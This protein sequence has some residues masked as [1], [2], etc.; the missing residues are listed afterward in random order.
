MQL[1]KLI[2]FNLGKLVYLGKWLYFSQKLLYLG[3]S[4][5]IWAQVVLFEHMVVFAQNGS[6]YTKLLYLRKMV[7]FAQNGC[8]LMYQRHRN[9]DLLGILMYQHHR[10]LCP[11]WNIAVSASEEPLSFLEY[12]CISVR[13]TFV[14]HGILLY[15]RHRSLDRLGI[16][17]YQ[18][19]RNL[20]PSW[21]IDVSA[22]QESLSFLEY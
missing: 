18:R 16:L 15:Q 3:K 19:H 2:V 13:G 1:G 11:S 8:V 10:N 14:L 12:C 20:C 9:L 6:I 4:G 21:N 17:I 5:C 7:V 22:S